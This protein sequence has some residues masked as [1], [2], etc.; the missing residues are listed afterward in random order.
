MLPRIP[1]LLFLTTTYFVQTKKH[2]KKNILTPFIFF[3]TK[4][5]T[6]FIFKNIGVFFISRFSL[7]NHSITFIKSQLKKKVFSFLYPG[8]EKKFIFLKRKRRVLTR[9]I[10]RPSKYKNLYFSYK[11]FFHILKVSQYSVNLNNKIRNY[12]LGILNYLQ[13][14]IN[15]ARVGAKDFNFYDVFSKFS[16]PYIKRVRFKPG[17]Q[18]LWR[19]VRA[20]IQKTL[21]VKFRYQKRLTRYLT[22][23]LRYS[24]R[25]LF[26]YSEATLTKILIFSKLLPNLILINF[27]S[28]KQFIYL[29]S[30]LIMSL[31]LIIIQ[32]DF[33][34]LIVTL[35]YYIISRWFLNWTIK[36]IKKFKRLV[37]FKNKA[38]KYRLSKTRKQK[39]HY[40]PN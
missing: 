16:E 27:F 12:S 26:S 17:Y 18:R 31:E 29:N 23:F 21:N 38:K 37:F 39:S 24:K 28:S 1:K 40:I 9:L 5:L 19:Q 34:Q 22:R 15:N 35:W 20:T 3:K 8:E 11:T 10:V 13:P 25:I 7:C 2:L 33:V 14:S 30:K 36:R 32:N 6:S 4:V